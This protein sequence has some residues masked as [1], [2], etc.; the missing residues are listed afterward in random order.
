LQLL[1]GVALFL[2]MEG[3]GI[4]AR[5][6][7]SISPLISSF[8]LQHEDLVARAKV[9]R[10]FQ[11]AIVRREDGEERMGSARTKLFCY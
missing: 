10:E 4:A 3:P 2:P 7:P 8:E 9:S 11:V 1:F 6:H 5:R